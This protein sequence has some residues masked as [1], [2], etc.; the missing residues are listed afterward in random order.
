MTFLIDEIRTAYKSLR[1]RTIA[2]CGATIFSQD[3]EKPKYHSTIFFIPREK[4][5]R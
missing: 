2:S 5:A 1:C 4:L 3:T